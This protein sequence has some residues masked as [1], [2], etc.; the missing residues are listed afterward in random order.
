MLRR[1]VSPIILVS[2]VVGSTFALVAGPAAARGGG[3]FSAVPDPLP[4][5]APG[6]IIRSESIP[7]P[8][9]AKAGGS[10]TT[11]RPSPAAT[12]PCRA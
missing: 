11:P 3:G 8:A 6:T 7:A 10:C 2:L 5:A 9:G 4:K 1:L 12:S